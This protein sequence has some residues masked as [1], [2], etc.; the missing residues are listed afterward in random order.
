VFTL[1]GNTTTS[2]LIDFDG[3]SS[4]RDLGNGN[5]QMTPVVRIL[6]VR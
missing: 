3:E 5:Y 1:A 6:S 4:I 2:I